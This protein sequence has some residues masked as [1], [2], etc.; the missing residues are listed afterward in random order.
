MANI[1]TGTFYSY[2]SVTTC[3]TVH[4]LVCTTSLLVVRVVTVLSELALKKELRRLHTREEA[5]VRR[6]R[7]QRQMPRSRLT[8]PFFKV[9]RRLSIASEKNMLG[10]YDRP[11]ENCAVSACSCRHQVSRG[12]HASSG[13]PGR[14]VPRYDPQTSGGAAEAASRR[15]G[16]RGGSV[17]DEEDGAHAYKEISVVAVCRGR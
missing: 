14:H 10:C 12:R 2:Q 9:A 15:P 11:D 5:A 8:F 3:G 7:R 1:C 17:F 13:H 6:W 16:G 4:S